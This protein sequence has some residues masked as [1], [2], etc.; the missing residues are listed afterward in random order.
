MKSYSKLDA[1][2]KKPN[3]IG[4]KYDLKYQTINK[5]WGGGGIFV[6]DT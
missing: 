4:N 6:S 3:T 2:H 5:S 1:V